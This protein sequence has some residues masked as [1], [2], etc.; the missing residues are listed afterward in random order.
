MSKSKLDSIMDDAK[1]LRDSLHVKANLAKLDTED[2]FDEL[3]AQYESLKEKSKRIADA[4]GDTA[5]EL[6]IAAE[7]GIN[8]DSKE[9]L[10]TV[11]ELAAEEVKKGYEKIK[12][13]I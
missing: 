13:I 11:L 12:K 10:H 8:S 6:S 7:M 2:G 1:T 5:E 9:D 3:E 4:A